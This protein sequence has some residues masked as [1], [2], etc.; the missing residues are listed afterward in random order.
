M[1]SISLV[2][3]GCETSG[4][5]I[6]ANDGTLLA[7]ISDYTTGEFISE[8][9]DLNAY[10]EVAYNEAVDILVETEKIDV[11]EAKKRL[12]NKKYAIYTNFDANAY[13]A[14]KDT[15]NTDQYEG[16]EFGCAVTNNTGKLLAVFSG[17]NNS[18]NFATKSTPP[19]SSIKPLSVYAPAIDSGVAEWSSVYKDAPVKKVTTD[20]GESVDWPS[21][22]NGQYENKNIDVK[23]AVKK[24][25]NTISV[26][27]LMDYGVTRSV[28]FLKDSFNFP[29]NTEEAIIEQY[30]E[31]E[32][33]GNIGM[34]YLRDGVSPIDMA[35]YYQ[36]FANGGKYSE[37]KAINEI[38][39]SY[40][41][42]I[43]KFKYE[44]GQ[45]IEESTSII[46]NKLL[47][48]VIK[49][50]ATGA[51]AECEDIEVGGKTGTGD[52]GNWFVGFT[53]EYSCAVWHGTQLDENN[54]PQ[55]F[56]DVIKSIP[57]K[58]LK[59]FSVTSDVKI[60]M[61]CCESGMVMGENC[62]DITSGY[63]FKDSSE[64]VCSLH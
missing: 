40:G 62:E 20:T 19:Y 48:E 9:S 27:C 7:T 15:Y 26:R 50:D 25:L 29:L 33:L 49:P 59:T 10:L 61:Y 14:I 60:L 23:T 56:A 8:D 24:S 16:L 57:N 46:M 37:P 13:K 41:D 22:A 31:E 63:F 44:A 58:I 55:I 11:A 30:G 17:G 35:G 4:L 3:C 43:Y 32:V 51:K 18:E 45:V 12:V 1:I 54:A 28:K 53:P 52:N 47:Q 6:Y 2:V 39:T 42:S 64:T 21:N 36:I 5:K 38:K 34:G